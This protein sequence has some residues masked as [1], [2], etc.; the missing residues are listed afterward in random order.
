MIHPETRE[1]FEAIRLL[2]EA[3][4]LSLGAFG[5]A[6][7]FNGHTLLDK[8]IDVLEELACKIETE[9]SPAEKALGS[10]GNMRNYIKARPKA[11]AKQLLGTINRTIEQ[12]GGKS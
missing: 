8:A 1:I 2:K 11:S 12:L 10:L 9:D 6:K 3:R 5:N 7:P 4:R